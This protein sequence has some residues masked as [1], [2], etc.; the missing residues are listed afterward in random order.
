M[1][2]TFF[3]GLAILLPLFITFYVL[4]FFIHLCTRPFRTI[5]ETSLLDLNI[6]QEG[7]WIFNHEQVLGFF[8]NAIILVFLASLLLFIGYLGCFVFMHSIIKWAEKLLLKI[9]FVNKIY[10]ACRDVVKMIFSPNNVSFTDVVWAP[11]PDKDKKALGLVSNVYEFPDPENRGRHF[12]P[13]LM[14]ETPNPTV[15][16]LLLLPKE[17]LVYTK[18]SPEEAMKWIISCGSSESFKVISSLNQAK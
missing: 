8:T 9:P 14:P 1:K 17:N 3:S 11:F 13:I 6:F 12:V 5:V 15:G 2:K 4:F 18:L 16:F 7:F 10:K